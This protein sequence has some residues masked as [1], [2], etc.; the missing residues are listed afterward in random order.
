MILP[1]TY[2][3]VLALMIL[4]LV[5]LGSWAAMF[6]LA[7]RWRFE[8]F[9]LDF[10]VGLIAAA[11]I[12]GFTVG[13]LGF[14]GF[15][16]LDDLQ[17]AGKRQWLF[18]FLAGVIFNLANMLLIAAVSVAGMAVSFAL[19]IGIAVLVGTGLAAASRPPSN[20]LML[21]LGCILML[22]CV[23]VAAASDRMLEIARHEVLARAGRATSTR[24]PSSIKGILLA[25][26][27]GVLMGVYS[28]L[29]EKARGGEVGMGP[30]A[31]TAMFALGA[32]FTSPIFDIFFMNLPVQ[33]EPL[34]FGM[35]V[36]TSAKQH[37]LGLLSG[38]IWC[39][40]ALAAMVAASVPD[41]IRAG[42]VLSYMLEHSWPVLAALWGILAF[43]EFKEG[44]ARVSILGVLM[45]VLFLCALGMIALGPLNI[46]GKAA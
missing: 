9:Y 14:D 31:L 21:T 10:A 27:A 15:N 36:N 13:N 4:S 30:Y 25:A 43:R 1:Q 17:H 19:G 41:E 6:K 2:P 42:P 22:T 44:D 7:G 40:G 3:V 18:A 11:A 33:G 28:P 39:T 5:C 24:R 20:T 46:A 38:V 16:F 34:D 29:L 37:L 32:F 8:L 23:V 45:L 35:I 12:Y 26:V